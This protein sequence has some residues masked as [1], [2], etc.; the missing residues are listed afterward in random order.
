MIEVNGLLHSAIVSITLLDEW[1]YIHVNA[2]LHCDRNNARLSYFYIIARSRATR[3]W[4]C[5]VTQIAICI[6]L[7]LSSNHP[8]MIFHERSP[9]SSNL[10]SCSP[11]SLVS[12]PTRDAVGITG[13]QPSLDD[14]A[15]SFDESPY[16]W[17]SRGSARAFPFAVATTK[18]RLN[19]GSQCTRH[20]GQ[21]ITEEANR[22]HGLPGS[23]GTVVAF[24]KHRGVS[25][26]RRLSHRR[27]RRR[28]LSS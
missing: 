18:A 26:P 19:H 28:R 20:H 13:K 10:G 3:L 15:T 9:I 5:R 12:S 14:E 27:R 6:P 16:Y 23:H 8:L 25:A 4:S 17:F 21:G 7:R 2:M 11:S 22:E 24:E 1:R